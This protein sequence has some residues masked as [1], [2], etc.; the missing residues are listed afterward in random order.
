MHGRDHGPGGSDAFTS[1]NAAEGDVVEADGEGGI[2]WGTSTGGSGIQFDTY[3]QA[4]G[5]LYVETGDSTGSPNG[6]EIDLQAAGTG[7]IQLN[8]AWN[9]LLN[10]DGPVTI[11]AGLT[12]TLAGSDVSIDGA[13]YS[14]TVSAQVKHDANP[15]TIAGHRFTIPVS[16]GVFEV[17]DSNGQAL[18]RVDGDGDL[19]GLTGKSLTFDL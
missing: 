12:L 1:R 5:W 13:S 6:W 4:G 18:F 14:M 16:G 10:A 8:S 7:G 15:S 9:I 19:H 17:I 3:P 2:R 11:G